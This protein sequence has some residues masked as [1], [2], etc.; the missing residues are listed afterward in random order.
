MA[1]ALGAKGGTAAVAAERPPAD[2]A[3]HKVARPDPIGPVISKDIPGPSR[4][5]RGGGN[6]L[7]LA[8]HQTKLNLLWA[9]N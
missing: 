1:L 5:G 7:H 8:E 3:S 9:D 6:T 4:N 2:R